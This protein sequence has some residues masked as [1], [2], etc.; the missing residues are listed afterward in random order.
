[1][2]GRLK[3]V[4]IVFYF[5]I[6]L[7]FLSDVTIKQVPILAMIDAVGSV[8]TNTIEVVC[9]LI[10]LDYGTDN[11]ISDLLKYIIL[12]IIGVFVIFMIIGGV[13]I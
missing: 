4:A 3:L 6:I 5:F 7:D 13:L 2:N 11:A 1:M 12:S 9:F 10:L 8:V